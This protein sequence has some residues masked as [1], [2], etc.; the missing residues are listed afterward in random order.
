M[1]SSQVPHKIERYEI[2]GDLPTALGLL[3]KHGQAARIIAGGSDL[4]I[5]L[6]RGQRKDISVLID[7]TRIP[8]LNA[9]TQDDDGQLHIGALVTHNQVVACLLYTSD[10]ADE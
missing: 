2:P 4:L 7:V 10:A 5:E 8:G 6:E 9:I 3:A 1:F